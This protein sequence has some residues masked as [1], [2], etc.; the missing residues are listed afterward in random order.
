MS[1]RNDVVKSKN[2]RQRIAIES[3]TLKTSLQDPLKSVS[4]WNRLR[5]RVEELR[6]I[7]PKPRT[8][9]LRSFEGYIK[10]TKMILRSRGSPGSA[11][12]PRPPVD[13]NDELRLLSHLYSGGPHPL[14]RLHDFDHL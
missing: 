8:H 6:L 7:P 13:E 14:G 11:R 1:S 12:P 4:T 2:H 3:S 10:K 9:S 5:S